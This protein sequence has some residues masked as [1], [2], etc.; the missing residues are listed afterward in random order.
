MI[1]QDIKIEEELANVQEK[2]FHVKTPK[3]MYFRFF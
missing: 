1:I 3:L 2:G